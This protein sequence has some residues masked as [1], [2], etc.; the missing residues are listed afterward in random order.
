MR[1]YQDFVIDVCITLRDYQAAP[2]AVPA[3]VRGIGDSHL[4]FAMPWLCY[5]MNAYV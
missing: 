1:V 3:Q 4:S 2:H 5:T